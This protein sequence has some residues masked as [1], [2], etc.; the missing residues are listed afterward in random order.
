VAGTPDR[1]RE[2]LYR[3]PTPRERERWHAPWLLSR[4]WA[5]AAVAREF[6]RDPHTIGAWLGDFRRAGPAGGAP[7]QGA[8]RPPGGGGGAHRPPGRALARPRHLPALPAP[9]GPRAR[10]PREA[11]AEGGGGQARR[12]R[13]PPRGPCSAKPR[14]WAPRSGSSVRPTSGPTPTRAGSGYRGARRA[15]PLIV[16][17]DNGG[18]RGRAAAR[19]PEDTRPAPNAGPAAGRQPGLQ[20]GQAPLGLGARGGDG[21]HLLRDGRQ[22][23]RG[24][25]PF[26]R[27]A[28]RARR[29]GHA[30]PPDRP[31]RPKPRHCWRGCPG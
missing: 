4:G 7:G 14:R 9:A 15:G 2:R 12:L 23:A 26:L 29:R 10:A 28:G 19:T 20:P 11:P 30:P 1:L 21:Q 16:I 17:R 31:S 22:G 24:S 3:S 25:G 5:A 13:G 6:G 27:R 8:S 18:A